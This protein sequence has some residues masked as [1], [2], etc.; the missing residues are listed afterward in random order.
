MDRAARGVPARNVLR[1]L[2]ELGFEVVATRGIHAKLRR[3]APCGGSGALAVPLHQKL[4]LG[5]VFAI[6]RQAA[7]FAPSRELHSTFFGSGRTAF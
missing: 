7:W 5:T 1:G 2:R 4:A 3:L 6:C